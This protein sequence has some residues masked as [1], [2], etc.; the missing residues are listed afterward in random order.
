MRPAGRSRSAAPR[1]AEA[2]PPSRPFIKWA[3]GKTQLL[4]QLDPLYP[5]ASRVS[6]YIEPFV[7]SGA[8]F[9][10]V[11][12]TLA[13]TAVVLADGNQG[14]IEAYTVV[15]DDVEA[16]I[17]ALRRHKARHSAD[18]YYRVRAQSPGRLTR[19]ARAARLIY[20][21]KTCFNGLYRVNSRGEFNVP[22]G[23]YEDPPILDAENLRVASGALRGVELR[24]GHFRETL[25]YARRGDFIYFD[26]PY[27]PLS[28]TSFFT[29]YT[30]G[31]FKEPDQAEL[32]AVYGELDARGC[33]VMLSNSDAPLI[34]ELYRAY[35]IRPVRARRSINSR[36]DRRGRIGEVVVIN[37]RPGSP[38]LPLDGDEG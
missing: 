30:D 5:P 13:P 10:H 36:A 12:A 24:A 3:G 2:P 20:L 7:G 18:H 26:P 19:V 21:N 23:R 1:P 33:L 15:R 35:D 37:Y 25:G 16:L 28:R 17:R 34:R 6:R 4:P 22:M 32:A 8:V 11:R 27:Q 31:A 9:F 29:A 14:L 38:S